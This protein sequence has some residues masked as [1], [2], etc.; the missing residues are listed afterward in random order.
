MRTYRQ[1]TVLGLTV[2]EIFLLLVFLLLFL[3]LFKQILAEDEMALFE[4]ELNLYK[5]ELPPMIWQRPEKVETLAEARRELLNAEQAIT[6]LEQHRESAT[7]AA[8]RAET[9][10]AEA[11]NEIRRNNQHQEELKQALATAEQNE[12]KA[13]DEA[14]REQTLRRKGENPPCWYDVVPDKKQGTRE[15]P[16]YSFNLAVYED[17]VELASREIPPGGAYDDGDRT[18][19]EEWEM[20]GVDKLP[21]GVRL[22][23]A[24]FRSTVAT[25]VQ[26]AKSQQVR[27]YECVFFVLV[28]DLTPEGAKER[29][30][31]ANETLLEERFGIYRVREDK[32]ISTPLAEPN[33]VG[34]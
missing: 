31:Y 23:D 19:A 20:V 25:M 5:Q 13:R 11:Q 16:I 9:R 10:L 27:T 28:W 22:N 33:V 12:D 34:D 7:V 1:G 2:A 29:W 24:E 14:L 26:M 15:K 3:L 4:Q 17:S 32:W 8:K 21:Y 6:E 18:F 30:Q